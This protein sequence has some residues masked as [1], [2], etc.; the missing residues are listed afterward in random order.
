MAAIASPAQSAEGEVNKTPI[1]TAWVY[2]PI[3]WRA[4]DW[5]AWRD[6]TEEDGL[7][8]WG[9]TPEEAIEDF[10]AQEDDDE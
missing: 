7:R 10:K 4:F 1:I 2:P 3:G 6:G 5:C 8:G 9:K